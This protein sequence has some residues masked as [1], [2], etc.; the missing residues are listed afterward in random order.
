MKSHIHILSLFQVLDIV[1][2]PVIAGFLNSLGIFLIQAQ[3]K[4]FRH[5]KLTWL[6]YT[7]LM[8]SIFTASLCF[9]IIKLLPLWKKDSLVPPSMVGLVTSS[10]IANVAKFPIKSLADTVGRT[11]FT[12]GLA[13]LPAYTGLPNVPFNVHTLSILLSTVV[14]SAVI[15][16]VE[17]LLAERIACDMYRC[18]VDTDFE[19]TNADRSVV[20][21][22]FG[23]LLS[24]FFGGF[25]GCGLIPNTLLNG[26]SG[27]EG[28]ASGYAYAFSMAIAVV[29]FSPILGNMP[30]AALAGLMF[31]VAGNTIQWKESK[32][33]FSNAIFNNH[34][35]NNQSN[36]FQN[37][38]D[39]LAMIVTT[40]VCYKYDMG[41][42]VV[43]GVITAKFPTIIQKLNSFYKKIT[44]KPS[45]KVV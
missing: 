31:T 38:A 45:L 36:T 21:L 22:G 39:L 3:L 12:G 37:Y 5:N 4:I 27:G 20:G 34:S 41:L 10:V 30:M 13:A 8:P 42:G 44:N 25:G 24:S 33:L 32:H 26:S 18:K 6:P 28:Y 9:M 16:V 43:I 15:C 29:L 23:N 19:A 14:G 7:S 11:K 1:T 40:F 35:S 17:T 2:E